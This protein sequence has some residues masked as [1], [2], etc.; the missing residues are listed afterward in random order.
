MYRPDFLKKL[1]WIILAVVFVAKIYTGSQMSSNFLQRGNSKTDLNLLAYNMLFYDQFALATNVPA[2]DFEPLYPTLMF[3]SYKL[4]GVNWHVL[5]YIQCLLHLFTSLFIFRIGARLWDPLAGFIAAVYY[6]FYPYLFT[7]SLGIYD[8]VPFI[9][10]LSGTLYFILVRPQH[11]KSFIAAGIFIG[12]AMLTRATIITFLPPLF[13]FILYTITT[14]ENFTAAAKKISVLVVA[15]TITVMP[16][17]IRNYE[18]TDKILVSTHGPFGFW[19]GN[20]EYSEYYLSNNISLDSVYRRNPAPEIYRKYPMLPRQPKDAVAT[21]N[22]YQEEAVSW[23]KENPEEFL[24]LGL[25]KAQKLW[26]WNRNP[27]SNKPKFG[28]NEGRQ[29]ANLISYLPLLA[30]LPFGL[31]LL[32]KKNKPVALLLAGILICFTGAHMLAMGFT[33]ARIPIDFLLMLSF[34]VATSYL[35]QKYLPPKTMLSAKKK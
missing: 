8:T 5:T 20:N 24:E 15:A 7:Y 11:Y 12:L 13:L 31:I 35:L 3:I 34:G 28:S 17:M 30:A 6:A 32:Y 33:R 16:W 23:V 10:L 27:T 19:Q 21:A 2:V 29:S 4:G 22:A 25:L 26:T 1:L 14:K 18:L 9:F